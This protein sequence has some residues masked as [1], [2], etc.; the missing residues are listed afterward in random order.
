MICEISPHNI[1]RTRFVS[2]EIT[3]QLEVRSLSLDFFKLLLSQDQYK[4]LTPGRRST[5][6]EFDSVGL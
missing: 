3:V 4:A 1:V 2:F 5:K 6:I